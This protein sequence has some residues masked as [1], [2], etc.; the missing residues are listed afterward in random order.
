MS[1]INKYIEIQASAQRN[2]GYGPA[3]N[4]LLRKAEKP[5][6]TKPCVFLSHIS[7]DKAAVHNIATYFSDAGV[8]Y[9]L[10]VD[11]PELQKAVKDGDDEKITN[12]IELGIKSSSHLLTIVSEK[13]Q[14]SW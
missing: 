11:D 1:G 8:D 5:P 14:R 10:D 6:K 9:Y 2:F 3:I 13:T 4:E 12:F 7:E